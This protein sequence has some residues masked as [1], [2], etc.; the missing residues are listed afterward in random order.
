MSQKYNLKDIQELITL[1]GSKN[2]INKVSHCL[3]RLRIEPINWEIIQEDKIKNL[4]FVKGVIKNS[5]E[6]QIIIG[7][8][9]EK[10]FEIFSKTLEEASYSGDDINNENLT[11]GT[12]KVK[13]KNIFSY[14]FE[15]AISFLSSVFIPLLP[16]L[17]SGGLILGLRNVIG[18]IPLIEGKTLTEVSPFWDGMNN[19]LWLIGEA[20]F[21]FLPVGI[22]WSVA[23]K[24]KT[25]DILGIILGITL[26]S[27]Q[28]M[29][30]YNIGKEVP[31]FWDFGFFTLD[32]VGYQAQVIP[33]LLAGIFLCYTE[34]G[35]NK[36]VP[37]SFYLLIVPILSLLVAVFVAHS[38]LGPIGR[39]LGEGVANGVKF[40]L[41]GNFAIIGSAIFGFLYAPLVITGIH[42]TTNAIEMQLIQSDGG[43]MIFPLLALNNIAQGSAALAIGILFKKNKI[44]EVAMPS[45]LSAYLGITE[46]AMYGVNL[47]L[48]LPMLFAMIGSA[49]GAT[50]CGLWGILA[51]GIGVGGIPGILSVK[52]QFWGYYSIAMLVS[53]LV[54][55][56]LC[57]IF[58]KKI[59][60]SASEKKGE[61]V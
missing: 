47:P 45:A 11:K 57:F 15:V 7:A 29:N 22:T 27:P 59:L 21:H 48:K 13:H 46:P 43:T 18:E 30:A 35:L 36:I 26:V 60:V 42:H 5:S 1:L 9:V 25:P 33:A 34:R 58:K 10:F 16:A 17:I 14:S 24:M 6:F 51:N 8:D 23:R 37:K 20:I 41:T 4:K 31:G 61:V 44:K 12:S 19:F 50:L 49:S 53:I 3:T 40:L 56:I 55:I 2:N 28:L 32:K 52:P 54:P 38:V 39:V